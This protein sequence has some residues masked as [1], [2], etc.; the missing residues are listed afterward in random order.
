MTD[1]PPELRDADPRPDDDAPRRPSPLVTAVAVLCL[2]GLV[3]SL[4]AGFLGGI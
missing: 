1:L 3:L 2:A 4:A